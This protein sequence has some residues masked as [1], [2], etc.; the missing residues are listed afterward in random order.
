MGY[1]EIWYE[2][3][4]P[5]AE[6]QRMMDA[7]RTRIAD[8]NA[9]AEALSSDSEFSWCGFTIAIAVLVGLAMFVF[10]VFLIVF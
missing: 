7:A 1:D 2:P 10:V 8:K 9:C 5:T 6:E 4:M 3:V